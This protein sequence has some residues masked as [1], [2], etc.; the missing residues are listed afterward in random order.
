MICLLFSWFSFALSDIQIYLV[1]DIDIDGLVQN[2]LYF[3]T[4]TALSYPLISIVWL[5]DMAD[6]C[7]HK[8]SWCVTCLDAGGTVGED[9]RSGV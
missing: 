7:A 5:V 4:L 3:S 2:R 6:I 1:I 8:Y 9:E